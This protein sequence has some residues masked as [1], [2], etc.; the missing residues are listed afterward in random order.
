MHVAVSGQPGMLSTQQTPLSRQL[1]P[2]QLPL[3]QSSS[4]QHSAQLLDS[5]Q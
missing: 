5:G 4:L 1:P 3:S 2:Q